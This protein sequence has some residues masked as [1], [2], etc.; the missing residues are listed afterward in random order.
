MVM[1]NSTG[2]VWRGTRAVLCC[3]ASQIGGVGLGGAFSG[4][5]IGGC[6]AFWEVVSG[7]MHWMDFWTCMNVVG[8]VQLCCGVQDL[9][10]VIAY[11]WCEGVGGGHGQRQLT[12]LGT[13]WLNLVEG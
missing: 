3:E 13:P 1:G 2:W 12:H 7:W 10:W 11:P 4:S 9:A 8:L 6:E 5:G